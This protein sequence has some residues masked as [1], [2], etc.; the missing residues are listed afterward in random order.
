MS[1]ILD[2]RSLGLTLLA[3]LGGLYTDF[4]MG[5]TQESKPK[6]KL[7]PKESVRAIGLGDG[8]AEARLIEIYRMIGGSGS[9]DALHKAEG[10]VFA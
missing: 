10:L 1:S 7:K 8:L 9:R 3:I 2:K 4:S 5:A 6:P